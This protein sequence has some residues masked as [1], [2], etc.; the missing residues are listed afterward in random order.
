MS[1]NESEKSPDVLDEVEAFELARPLLLY[2]PFSI[3]PELIRFV[4][5]DLI[6]LCRG[7]PFK[8]EYWNASEIAKWLVRRV[9]EAGG[10]WSWPAVVATF[11]QRFIRGDRR[12]FDVAL[13]HAPA[14]GADLSRFQCVHCRD[15]GVLRGPDGEAQACMWC[16]P[17]QPKAPETAPPPK[18]FS[19]A[20]EDFAIARSAL[21]HSGTPLKRITQADVDEVVA[22]VRRQR[23]ATGDDSGASI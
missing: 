3:R 22:E 23:A 1:D 4:A 11:E 19:R 6:R 7:Q 12:D 13:L 9:Y 18:R 15:R 8:G 20:D 16:T 17:P 2:K 10:E 14:C 5:E 21:I